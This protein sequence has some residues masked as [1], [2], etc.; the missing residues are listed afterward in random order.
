MHGV[1]KQETFFDPALSQAFINLR[2]DVDEGTACWDAEPQFLS[3]AFH[4][5]LLSKII[6]IVWNTILKRA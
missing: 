1:A 6:K 4:Y 5:M 3:V 2:R